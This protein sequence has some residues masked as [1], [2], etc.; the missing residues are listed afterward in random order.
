MNKPLNRSRPLTVRSALFRV[1][2]LDRGKPLHARPDSKKHVVGIF[3][4]TSQRAG[5]KKWRPILPFG[6]QALAA[7]DVLEWLQPSG[8]RPEA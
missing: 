1:L 3:L 5:P 4:V 8:R 7:E 2:A 6:V